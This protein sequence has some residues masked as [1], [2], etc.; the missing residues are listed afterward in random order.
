MDCL[1]DGSLVE[2]G[3]WVCWQQ[4]QLTKVHGGGGYFGKLG[5]EWWFAGSWDLSKSVGIRVG[6]PWK[7]LRSWRRAWQWVFHGR[8][9]ERKRKVWLREEKK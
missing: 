1:F 9:A 2:L 5:F 3:E 8:V 7:G 6:F 4:G